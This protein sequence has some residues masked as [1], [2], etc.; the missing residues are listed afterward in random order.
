MSEW[1]KILVTACVGFGA[2]MLAETVKPVLSGWIKRRQ[3]R[4]VLYR[5]LALC[6]MTLK[7]AQEIGRDAKDGWQE[8]VYQRLGELTPG[9]Y[10]WASSTEAAIFYTMSEAQGF[11]VLYGNLSDIHKETLDTLDRALG[12]IDYTL[13][14]LENNLASGRLS[15]WRFNRAVDRHRFHLWRWYRKSDKS[16]LLS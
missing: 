11:E 2:G 6:T 1:Q 10:T 3:I 12:G 9:P 16:G 14:K 4:I 13:R 15:R 7:A 5:H 8:Y